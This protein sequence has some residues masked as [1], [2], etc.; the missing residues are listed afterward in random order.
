MSMSP[1]SLSPSN[2]VVFIPAGDLS[3]RYRLHANGA[4]DF[5]HLPASRR[6]ALVDRAPRRPT[7]PVF[8]DRKGLAAWHHEEPDPLVQVA[9]RGLPYPFHFSAGETLR[10]HAAAHSLRFVSQEIDESRDSLSVVTRLRSAHG[11][12]ALHRVV[13]SPRAAGLLVET[14]LRNGSPEPLEVEMLSS[15]SL[16]GISPFVADDAPGRLRLHRFRSA[17]SNEARHVAEDFEPLHLERTWGGAPVFLRYGQTGSLPVRG[18]FPFAAI[19]DRGAGVLWGAQIAWLGSWQL[20]VY[21]R[22]DDVSLSGGL[23]DFDR[24]HWMKRLA[25]GERFSGPPALLTAVAGDIDDLCARLLAVQ[26]TLAHPEPEA[27]HD[28]PII[29]NEWCST[30]G[31]PTH[32][33]ILRTADRLASTPTRYLVIDDGWAAKPPGENIQFNGDWEINTDAFPG[34]FAPTCAALRERG[35]VPGLWFEFEPCTRGTRAFEHTDHLLHR[36]GRVLEVGS[37]RFWD[38]RDPWTFEYLAEKV[39]RRLRDS[40]FGYLKVDYNECVGPGCD[41]AESLGEGLRQHLA[42]VREFFQKIRR[43]VPGIVVENCSSGGHREEPGMIALTSM[44]SFSDAHETVEIPVISA[45]LLRLV[46]ARKLQIWAVLRGDDP[47]PRMRYSLAAT[48]LGRMCVSGEVVTL[49]DTRFSL[50]REAQEFYRLC[51]PVLRDGVS[52][53]WFHTGASRRYPSGW[54]A[55]VR[56]SSDGARALVVAHSFEGGREGDSLRVPLP[57][58]DWTLEA[59]YGEQPAP[60]LSEGELAFPNPADFIGQAWLLR[61]GPRSG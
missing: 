47:L 32:D 39:I 53:P 5:L 34:G 59:S 16:T 21:R 35:F 12:E 3:L 18:F 24:A 51:A 50:L 14:E 43:E 49:D 37:R 10:D 54:Q 57:A 4:V 33:Y 48:F 30:W 11:F 56:T 60:T 41:G 28:L 13:W 19:E 1:R 52:R 26:D 40:G 38:F 7:H 22:G 15:F 61:R 9:V 25:P 8:A 42:K 55:V 44:C 36:H 20:E 46:P 17:W 2:P 23:G 29:F 58:G 31:K 27:E 6:D 45:S